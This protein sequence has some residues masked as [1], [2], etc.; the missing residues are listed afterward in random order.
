MNLISGLEEYDESAYVPETH[1][2]GLGGN[3]PRS[4]QDM[5]ERLK[6]RREMRL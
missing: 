2:S 1:R 4:N 3:E 5:V 6:K